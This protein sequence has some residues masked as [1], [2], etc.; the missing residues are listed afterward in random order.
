MGYTSVRKCILIEI[1]TKFNLIREKEWTGDTIS[2]I[3]NHRPILIG[4]KAFLLLFIPLVTLTTMTAGSFHFVL[5]DPLHCGIQGSA[6][7]YSVGYQ[8]GLANPGKICPSDRVYYCAGWD[9]GASKEAQSPSPQIQNSNTSRTLGQQ[10]AGQSTISGDNQWQEF[11]LF[12]GPIQKH[13]GVFHNEN[14]VFIPWTT[15]CNAGQ[16]YL[17]ESCLPHSLGRLVD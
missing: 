3:C 4:S 17:A 12:F 7:C 16:S 9:G 1:R 13:T 14:G 5:A 8:N 15:L 10:Q 6:S 2:N 11:G